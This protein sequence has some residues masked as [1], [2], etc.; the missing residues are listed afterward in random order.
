MRSNGRENCNVHLI[1]LKKNGDFKTIQI[2]KLFLMKEF[3]Q[4]IVSKG[5]IPFMFA[6]K[7]NG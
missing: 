4:F 1:S 5:F 7:G 2:T 6:S 3:N